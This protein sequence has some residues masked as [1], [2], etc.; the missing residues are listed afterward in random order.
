MQARGQVDDYEFDD[1]IREKTRK[2]NNSGYLPEEYEVSPEF[3]YLH[4]YHF[5][6]ED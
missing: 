6:I 5:R 1:G 3:P 2:G 4:D